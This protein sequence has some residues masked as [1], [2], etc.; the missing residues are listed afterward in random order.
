[1][2]AEKIK[3]KMTK[4]EKEIFDSENFDK[5]IKKPKKI[6]PPVQK[7]INK[8]ALKLASK[9]SEKMPPEKVEKEIEKSIIINMAKSTTYR[10]NWSY[11]KRKIKLF[12]IIPYKKYERWFN[13]TFNAKKPDLLFYENE[14]DI[15]NNEI[16]YETPKEILLPGSND[17]LKKP[18]PYSDFQ[19]E[20]ELRRRNNKPGEGLPV[21]KKILKRPHRPTPL[22]MPEIFESDK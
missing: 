9:T 16:L 4:E 1:M 19:K 14:T 13:N 6:S 15:D 8:D 22:K 10:F 20:Q 18:I 2:T 12:F 3:L 7:K 21:E 5:T 17:H 11:A